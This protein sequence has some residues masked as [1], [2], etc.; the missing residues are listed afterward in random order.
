M[1]VPD[2]S[3]QHESTPSTDLTELFKVYFIF[4]VLNKIVLFYS[5]VL[6]GHLNVQSFMLKT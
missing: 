5:K 4:H 1:L 3:V 6:T 2:E